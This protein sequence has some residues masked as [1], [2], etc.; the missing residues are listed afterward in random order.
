MASWI[1]RHDISS[2]VYDMTILFDRY[3]PALLEANKNWQRIT[4]ITEVAMLQMTCHL[5]ECL[6]TP[7]NLPTKCP[8]EWYE[9]YFVFATIWGFGSSLYCDQQIDWR[10]EFSKFWISEFQT[11]KFP[12]AGSVFDY[13]VDPKS[14]QF[15]HWNELVPKFELDIEQPLQVRLLPV[16]EWGMIGKITLQGVNHLSRQFVRNL[17]N[18]IKNWIRN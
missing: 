18:V 13:Y 9:I 6:I 4:P 1:E 14:K 5:L 15:R 11:I 16:P 7:E 3:I 17:F 12:E 2:E 8:N 10:L